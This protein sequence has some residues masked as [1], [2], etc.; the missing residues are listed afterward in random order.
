MN[1]EITFNPDGTGRCLHTDAIRLNSIGRLFVARAT[2]I[3]FD[4]EHQ[5]WRVYD[6]AGFPMF[7][8]PSRQ[9]C[10]NWERRYLQSQEDMKHGLQHRPRA[11]AVG[12]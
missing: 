10:L 11:V 4:N 9:E 5:Y 3:E 7:N 1:V 6:A 2:N 12:A 8:S